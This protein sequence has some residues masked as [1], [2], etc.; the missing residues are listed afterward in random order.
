MGPGAAD[1]ASGPLP[2]F[3][4]RV[5]FVATPFEGGPAAP[6]PSE[7]TA[8]TLAATAPTRKR[9]FHPNAIIGTLPMILV[10]VGVFVIGIGFS[11]LWSFTSSKLFPNP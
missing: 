10:S 2:P 7:P 4:R 1:A 5:P 3:G 11:V 9:R 6:R 8:V